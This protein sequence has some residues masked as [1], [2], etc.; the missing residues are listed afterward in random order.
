MNMQG[1][2]LL[3]QHKKPLEDRGSHLKGV[4][5]SGGAE[6]GGEAERDVSSCLGSELGDLRANC[7][8]I[9][10][11]DKSAGGCQPPRWDYF[12]LIGLDSEAC[13]TAR[14]V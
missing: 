2:W 3:Q 6:R 1:Y 13:A 4:C 7:D 14:S 8:E 5:V 9:G 10:A 12:K 11:L